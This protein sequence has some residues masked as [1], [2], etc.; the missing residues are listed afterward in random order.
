MRVAVVGAGVSGLAAARHLKAS[1]HDVIVFEKSRGLGGRCATRRIGPYTFDTGAT[2]ITP[3]GRKIERVLLEELPADD[4]VRIDKPIFTHR[5]GRISP[6]DAGRAGKDRYAYRHGINTLGKRLA[7]GLDVRLQCRIESL[8]RIPDGGYLVEGEVFDAAILTPPIPQS[9]ELLRTVG[10]SRT[11]A[12][13]RYRQVLSV[14]LGYDASFDPP[15]HALIDPDQTETLM[16]LSI[17]STKCPG[18][19]APEGH[20]AIVA[21]MSPGFSQWH[22]D[23]NRDDVIKQAV[24]DVARLIGKSFPAP[25]VTDVMKWRYSQPETTTTFESVNQPG[26]RLVVAGDGLTG[27]RIENA[28]DCGIRA[29]DHL[30][31]SI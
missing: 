20:T 1:G 26:S 3:R 4:L 5:F 25:V 21:Q 24:S 17:E 8:E 29:A 14:L 9:E 12:N 19:R 7:E 13:V 28:F 10:E 2:T 16:W 18:D 15:Y 22:F 6:G 23:R 31:E 11:F 30:L 27:G